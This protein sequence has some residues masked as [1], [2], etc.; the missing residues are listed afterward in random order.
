M[1]R[2]GAV[3]PPW[4]GTAGI[5]ATTRAAAVPERCAP[6]ATLARS[7]SGFT[8]VAATPTLSSTSP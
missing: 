5:D 7:V 4:Q 8:P 6:L 3:L 2:I 1:R